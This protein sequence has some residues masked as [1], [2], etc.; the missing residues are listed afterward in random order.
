[1]SLNWALVFTEQF[2]V[3]LVLLDQFWAKRYGTDVHRQ[4]HDVPQGQKDGRWLQ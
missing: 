3:E 4:P 1:M 2:E